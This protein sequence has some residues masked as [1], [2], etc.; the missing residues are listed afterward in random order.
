MLILVILEFFFLDE[1]KYAFNDTI[2]SLNAGMLSL[3]FKF[4]GYSVSAYFYKPIYD[5]IHIVSSSIEQQVD[6]RLTSRT[7]V[8]TRGCYAFSLRISC[9]I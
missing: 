3:L 8:L 9:I 4:G 5:K 1:K 7:T 6:L 2:T